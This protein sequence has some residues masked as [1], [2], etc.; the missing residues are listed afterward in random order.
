M[1]PTAE[2]TYRYYT[3]L[4]EYGTSRVL[5]L[6]TKDGWT[7]PNWSTAEPHFWQTCDHVNRAMLEMY[8]IHVTTLRCMYVYHDPETGLR[9]RVH[10]LDNHSPDWQPP[11]GARWIDRDGLVSLRLAVPAHRQLIEVSFDEAEGVGDSQLRVSWSRRGWYETA[12]RWIEDQ[13]EQIG[14]YMLGSPEQLRAWDRSC[15]M[16]VP[17]SRGN[18]YFKALPPMFAHEL[19]LLDKLAE[20]HP[21]NFPHLLV[22]DTEHIWMLMLDFGGRTL[23]TVADVEVWEGALRE[24]GRL[25]IELA[26]KADTLVSA[27]VP[28]RGLDWLSNQIDWLIESLPNLNTYGQ[29]PLTIEELSQ[30][31]ELAPRLKEKCAELG[32]YNIPL[33]LEHGDLWASNIVVKEEGFLYFDWSDC[34]IAHPFFSLTVFYGETGV[35]LPSSPEIEARLRDSYL[36]PWIRFEPPDRLRHAFEIAQV[37]APLHGALGYYTHILPN[38]AHKWEMENMPPFFLRVMLERMLK[39]ET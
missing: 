6:P 27:G 15:V 34:S 19:P 39:R 28:Y 30:L 12:V 22:V 36:Q 11:E 13:V 17:T 21:R 26:A 25:Q 7:L 35:E 1:A 33:S 18:L 2:R 29:T 24:L 16:R 37:L 32:G 3:I 10:S 38:M 5:L 31:C 14:S 20:W 9:Q 4:P 8:S 23:D